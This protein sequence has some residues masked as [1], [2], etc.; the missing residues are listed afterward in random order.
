MH[1]GQIVAEFPREM[2]TQDA[3]MLAATGGRKNYGSS[4]DNGG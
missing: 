2:A 1:E 4:A 3:I